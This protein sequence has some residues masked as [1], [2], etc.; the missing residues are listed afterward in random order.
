MSDQTVSINVVATGKNMIFAYLLWWFLGAV[1]VHRF[2]LGKPATGF[3]QLFL[4]VAGITTIIF[5]IGFMFLFA[6]SVWW[7]L[8]AYFVY[9][10][11]HKANAELGIASSTVSIVK[12]SSEMDKLDQLDKLHALMENGVLTKEQY[13]V[14]TA[15]LI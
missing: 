7:F 9:K 4:F 3:A 6:W 12:S 14:K 2:Y 15:A 10:L 8:D 5:G 13:E 1:G 11:V